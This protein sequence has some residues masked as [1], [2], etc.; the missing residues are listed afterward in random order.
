LI[1]PESLVRMLACNPGVQGVHSRRNGSAKGKGFYQVQSLPRCCQAQTF[2]L[3]SRIGGGIYLVDM[4]DI[5]L[6]DDGWTLDTK[7]AV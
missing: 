5:G 4:D 2:Q 1:D 3:F 6:R 7:A